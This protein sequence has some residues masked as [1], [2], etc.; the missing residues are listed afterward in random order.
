MIDDNDIMTI[1]LNQLPVEFSPVSKNMLMNESIPLGVEIY[2]EPIDPNNKLPIILGTLVSI[3]NQSRL[4]SK[5]ILKIRLRSGYY[6]I[7]YPIKYDVFYKQK[8]KQSQSEIK[9]DRKRANMLALL[10]QLDNM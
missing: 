10:E 9:E 2:A 4:F 8:V 7:F 1:T 5:L 6:R 3:Q